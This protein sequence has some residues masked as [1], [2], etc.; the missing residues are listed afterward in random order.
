M[1]ISQKNINRNYFSHVLVSF[2]FRA[3]FLLIAALS[4]TLRNLRNTKCVYKTKIKYI[5]FYI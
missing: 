1:N 5:I 3:T 2:E 4:E